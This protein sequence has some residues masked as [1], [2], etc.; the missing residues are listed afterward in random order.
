[1]E[2]QVLDTVLH[3]YDSG[4]LFDIL[5]VWWEPPDACIERVGQ[6]IVV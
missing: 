1:M 3:P 2:V 5:P 4:S 6:G